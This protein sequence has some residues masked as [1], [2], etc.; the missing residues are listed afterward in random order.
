MQ[1]LQSSE[2]VSAVDEPNKR[3]RKPNV[4]KKL[5][6]IFDKIQPTSDKIFVLQPGSQYI[7]MGIADQLVCETYPHCIA[8]PTEAQTQQMDFYYPEDEVAHSQSE[9]LNYVKSHKVRPIPNGKTNASNFNA[10]S[11]QVELEDYNDAF[12]VDWITPTTDDDDTFYVGEEARRIASLSHAYENSKPYKLLHPISNG[13][14]NI[15]DY[16]TMEQLKSDISKIWTFH[17]KKLI[18]DPGEYSVMLIVNDLLDRKTMSLYASVLMD[19]MGFNA[20][21]MLQSSVCCGLA[22][23]WSAC[24]VVDIGAQKTSISCVEN[25]LSLPYSRIFLPC[26]GDDITILLSYLLKSINFP[27]LAID[28]KPW[29]YDVIED[30]KKNFCSHDPQ[31]FKLQQGHVFIRDFKEKTIKMEFKM[32]DEYAV[33]PFT[34]FNEHL[35]DVHEK[36]NDYKANINLFSNDPELFVTVDRIKHL[37]NRVFINKQEDEKVGRKE[38]YR[39]RSRAPNLITGLVCI[40]H[41]RK[42][43]LLEKAT[44]VIKTEENDGETAIDMDVDNS[45]SDSQSAAENQ[46]DEQITFTE[47]ELNSFFTAS[48][49]TAIHLSMQRAS[50]G[51][52]DKVAKFS[53]N[54]LLVG[55]GAKMKYL[56]KFIEERL[57]DRLPKVQCRKAPRELD[58]ESVAWQGAAETAKIIDTWITRNEW[59]IKREFA[60][61][62]KAYFV[63]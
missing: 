13:L 60:I 23:G 46:A 49:D 2:M 10:S 32:M 50:V 24:T 5:K 62:D 57:V 52:I 42:D 41:F 34:L 36:L 51:Q 11:E 28:T 61:N 15:K 18:N 4:V 9:V 43:L 8:H 7:R 53:A 56:P 6:S 55:G 30:I 63:W 3:K 17:S 29:H 44:K 25:G 27:N 26:G 14:L 21:Q 20:I 16:S 31:D 48:L 38:Q 54:I 1:S 35:F 59:E 33:A 37:W 40:D 22:T 12:L 58:P 45:D 19:V 47:E 39:S